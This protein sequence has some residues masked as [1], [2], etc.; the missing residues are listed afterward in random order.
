MRKGEAGSLRTLLAHLEPN[1][2]CLT[3]FDEVGD[4]EP[5]AELQATTHAEAKAFGVRAVQTHLLQLPAIREV[6]D[7]PAPA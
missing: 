5:A 3:T 4:E 6:R 7:G 1:A 2:V